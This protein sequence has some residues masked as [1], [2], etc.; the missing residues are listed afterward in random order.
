MELCRIK[1]VGDMRLRYDRI[2]VQRS[3]ARERSSSSDSQNT[4]LYDVNVILNVKDSLCFFI[5]SI[6]RFKSCNVPLECGKYI[7]TP[8]YI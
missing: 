4:L 3:A 8:K 2:R 1:K 7:I 6:K 5:S